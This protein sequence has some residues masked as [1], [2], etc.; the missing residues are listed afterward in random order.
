VHAAH[1]TSARNPSL[2]FTA[3]PW[4]RSGVSDN[5]AARRPGRREV[6]TAASALPRILAR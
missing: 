3:T 1:A 2:S 5:R 4:T 6:P